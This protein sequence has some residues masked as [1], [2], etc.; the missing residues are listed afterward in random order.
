MNDNEYL[1]NLLK[2]REKERAA[3]FK[4]AQ[5]RAKETGKE[6]F[7][8][9]KLYDLHDVR[10][11]FARGNTLPSEETKQRYEQK[12]YIDYSDVMSIKEFAER[13]NQLDAYIP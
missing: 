11:D 1:L 12:Y 7:D 5:E 3:A 8:F 2:K 9:E 13:L 4:Q 10:S 6:P